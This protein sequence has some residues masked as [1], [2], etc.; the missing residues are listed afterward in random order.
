MWNR[1]D[2]STAGI[3]I[4]FALMFLLVAYMPSTHAGSVAHAVT[5][6]GSAQITT[7]QSKFGGASG[8]F[9]GSGDYLS[10]TDSDDWT[11]GSG[12]F[13]ID[14]W[15]RFNALPGSAQT[16]TALISLSGVTNYNVAIEVS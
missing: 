4:T 11:F 6:Y 16:W 7:G 8:L 5:A 13:T 12:D 3:V 14:F 1:S 2:R 10:T 15:V 9:H